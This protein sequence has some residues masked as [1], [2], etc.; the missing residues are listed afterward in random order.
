MLEPGSCV[1][2]GGNTE[3]V[4]EKSSLWQATDLGECA[5]YCVI[6]LSFFL[7]TSLFIYFLLFWYLVILPFL[8]SFLVEEKK[9][10]NG[11]FPLFIYEFVLVSSS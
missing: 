1:A 6:F 4:G 8:C 5:F 9:V 10:S 3:C 2:N 7:V 11:P